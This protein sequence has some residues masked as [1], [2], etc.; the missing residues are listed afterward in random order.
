[1]KNKTPN[2]SLT[3]IDPGPTTHQ[4]D[5]NTTD[6]QLWQGVKSLLLLTNM[7]DY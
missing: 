5:T 2:G 3:G 4:V 7:S 1:M 6:L